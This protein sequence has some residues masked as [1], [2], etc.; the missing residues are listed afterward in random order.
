MCRKGARGH[1]KNDRWNRQAELIGKNRSQHTGIGQFGVTHAILTLSG[2]CP[3]IRPSPAMSTIT[4]LGG[5][6][7]CCPHYWFLLIPFTNLTRRIQRRIDPPPPMLCA[8]AQY[9]KFEL[10]RFPIRIH[11]D[12][13]QYAFVLQLPLIARLCEEGDQSG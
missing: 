1:Q 11:D 9:R 10:E 13:H 5:S 2:I 3:A 8:A 7:I 6:S 12:V 4:D